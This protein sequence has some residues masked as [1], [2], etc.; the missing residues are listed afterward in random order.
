MAQAGT[1]VEDIDL[2]EL[3]DV[4][5]IYAALSLEA[6]GFAGRGQGWRLASEGQIGRSGRIPIST[7]GGSKARG[8]AG[9]ATG[10]YQVV[11]VVLQLQER[12]AGGQVA[13]ARVGMA[14]C[15][16]GAGATAATHVLARTD[17]L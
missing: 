4:F 14:Q 6:A 16:G 10:I 2:F 15:L 9:G 11:E 7:L 12:A 5:S 8:D 3:H 17:G 13:G 1:P